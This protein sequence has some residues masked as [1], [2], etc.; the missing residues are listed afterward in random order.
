VIRLRDDFG[1]YA[2]EGHPQRARDRCGSAKVG[3]QAKVTVPVGTSGAVPK[4][5]GYVPANSDTLT[6]RVLCRGRI[7][8]ANGAERV[9]CRSRVTGSPDTVSNAQFGIDDNPPAVD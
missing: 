9:T 4:A 8:V 2:A 6:L 1:R 3:H 7:V 5:G